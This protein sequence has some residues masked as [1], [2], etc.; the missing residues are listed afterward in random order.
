[1][2]LVV[3]TVRDAGGYCRAWCPALPGCFTYAPSRAEAVTKLQETIEGYLASF[4]TVS[5]VT[6]DH[7]ELTEAVAENAVWP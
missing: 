1:M 4:D 5:A 6:V 7:V 3:K 2:N